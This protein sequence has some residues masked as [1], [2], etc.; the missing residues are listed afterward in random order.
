MHINANASAQLAMNL[1]GGF[2]T[3]GQ[4]KSHTEKLEIA[5]VVLA[6][7]QEFREDGINITC[8]LEEARVSQKFVWKIIWDLCNNN[9]YIPS[10]EENMLS[11]V[12]LGGHPVKL[13]PIHKD[14]I[15]ALRI[16][17]PYLQL[18]EV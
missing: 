4:G 2:Y 7:I 5:S 9:G 14:F 13:E 8:I 18:N 15:I 11:Q 16:D 17:N 1:N 10:P 12:S 6:H 3:N